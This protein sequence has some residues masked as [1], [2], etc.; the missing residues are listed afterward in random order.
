MTE[1]TNKRYT[2][3]E[4]IANSIVSG[5]GTAL[6]IAGLVIL[7]IAAAQRGDAWHIVSVSIF[8]TTLIFSHLAS[9]L[10]HSIAPPR[11]KRVLQIIDHLA[12]YLLIAG[13][14]TPFALVNLRGPWGWSLFAAI[15]VLAL[16]GLLIKLTPLDRVRGLSTGF[17]VAMGWVV[18]VAIKPLIEQV[19]SGGLWLLLAGGLCYTFGVVFYAWRKLKFGH[20]I[21]HVFVLAG[22]ACHYFA[23]LGYV[24]P[25]AA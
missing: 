19:E 1:N 9:T 5:I 23:V 24:I 18:V 20:A 21:W 13:T 17:Y 14:Y 8:G 25:A 7:I 12:I 15:W 6:A 10:Y 16:L 4:E 2:V 22:S 11:A 3:G